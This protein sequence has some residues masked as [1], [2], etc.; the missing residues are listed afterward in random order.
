MIATPIVSQL[1]TLSLSRELAGTIGLAD[2]TARLRRAWPR[3]AA[4]LLL[5]YET[6]GGVILPGQWFRDRE[7]LDKVFDETNQS[8]PNARALI[9]PVADQRIMLQTGGADRTLKSL[10]NVLNEPEAALVV[11]RPEQ[12]AVVRLGG[13]PARTFVKVVRPRAAGRVLEAFQYFWS[14]PGRW[15]AI[16]EVCQYDPAEGI[17]RLSVLPGQSLFDLPPSRIADSMRQA[18]QMLRYVHDLQ[19]PS[20]AKAHGPA[21]E[22]AVLEKWITMAGALGV[23]L[24]FRAE[25]VLATVADA[26]TREVTPSTLLHRDFHDQQCLVDA[27]GHIGLLDFDTLAVGEP[28]LD[29][30]NMLGHLE[31]R[32]WQA[33]MTS[34][35]ASE[36]AALFLDGYSPHRRTLARIQAYIDS[37]RLRLACVYSFRPQWSHLVDRLVASIG[38]PCCRGTAAL[39]IQPGGP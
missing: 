12:R 11:H 33:R 18:G 10:V 21:E 8:S 5:E 37:T 7:A 4:H 30:A 9:L 14:A 29:V 35:G 31:L 6:D 32:L 16:P 39:A 1:A 24:G 23:H 2:T 27:E 34:I 38:Q 22:V 28:A 15:F 26:L 13:A 36:A 17:L 20:W 25:E 19:P 3:S